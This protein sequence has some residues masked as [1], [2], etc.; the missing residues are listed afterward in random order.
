VSGGERREMI[1]KKDVDY[2][3]WLA[4]LQLSE[5]EKERFTRQLGQVLEHAEMIRS[6]DIE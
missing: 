2:V 5:E 6:L 1:E 4:R 3:A